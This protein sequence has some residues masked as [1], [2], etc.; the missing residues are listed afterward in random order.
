MRPFGDITDVKASGSDNVDATDVVFVKTRGT[1]R[2]DPTR[3][4]K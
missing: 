1:V 3:D 2:A 4:L